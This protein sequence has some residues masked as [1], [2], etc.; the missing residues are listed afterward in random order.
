MPLPTNQLRYLF[1]WLLFLYFIQKHGLLRPGISWLVLFVSVTCVRLVFFGRF[2]HTLHTESTFDFRGLWEVCCLLHTVD[3]YIVIPAR[4]WLIF[5]I[6]IFS[7]VEG[8]CSIATLL[9]FALPWYEFKVLLFVLLMYILQK[10]FS[11]HWSFFYILLFVCKILMWRLFNVLL[12]SKG[13]VAFV[14]LRLDVRY[15]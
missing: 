4:L 5:S 8:E 6:R 13:V 15:V 3:L 12:V 9:W 14:V 7:R 10:Y 11:M 2:V 1:P